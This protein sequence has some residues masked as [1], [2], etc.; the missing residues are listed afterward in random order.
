MAMPE[1][2]QTLTLTLPHPHPYLTLTLT[3]PY[4]NPNPSLIKNGP[5]FLERSVRAML[6][7]AGSYPAKG[8]NNWLLECEAL[9]IVILVGFVFC[10]IF[11]F[12][13]KENII[14]VSIHFVE[15]LIIWSN[16]YVCACVCLCVYR[17]PQDGAQQMSDSRG[18]LKTA[19]TR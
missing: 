11:L 5:R 8:I 6:E 4:P 10:G 7:T 9:I 16:M 1:K 18:G 15:V 12:L 13:C 14:H 3:Y 17:H 19:T 2:N